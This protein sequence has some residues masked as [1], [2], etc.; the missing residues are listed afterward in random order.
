MDLYTVLSLW[1]GMKCGSTKKSTSCSA[2]IFG[3]IYAI[4]E[5]YQTRAGAQS[6]AGASPRCGRTKGWGTMA[7][8]TSPRPV[9]RDR[10]AI[11]LTIITAE[12]A[13]R[14]IAGVRDSFPQIEPVP[15]DTA[16]RALGSSYYF[17]TLGG[18]PIRHPSAYRWPKV[19]HAST[20]RIEVGRAWLYRARRRYAL[21]AG[22][23]LIDRRSITRLTDCTV[24][25]GYDGQGRTVYVVYSRE[26][27][28]HGS[29]G[30][31]ALRTVR[32]ARAAFRDR[33]KL[34]KHL[35][36]ARRVA[37]RTWVSV[38]DSVRG[39]NCESESRRVAYELAGAL[40]GI[41]CGEIVI[42]AVRG[43]VLLRHRSDSYALR[44][45]YAAATRT[46]TT[47]TP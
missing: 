36:Y 40:G 14:R 35:A 12:R 44:A 9:R 41:D 37:P 15:G 1:V 7:A 19:Y 32:A 42:G 27:H 33:A 10:A 11:E 20:R 43:D 25:Q 5:S 45:I 3:I 8:E 13:A 6:P 28:Y 34:R 29:P 17:S 16:P 39:G 2:S 38:E 23:I 22:K 24:A 31:T 4:H 21:D 47:E 30:Q 26:G 46:S 18:T